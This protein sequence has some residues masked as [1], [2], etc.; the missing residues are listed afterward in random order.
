MARPMRAST[1]RKPKAR[2]MISRSFVLTVCLPANG[3]GPAQ[4]LVFGSVIV[5]LLVDALVSGFVA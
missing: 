1:E 5:V 4:R 3:C 2:R